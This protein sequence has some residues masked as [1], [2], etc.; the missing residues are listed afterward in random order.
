[1]SPKVYDT[2]MKI[3]KFISN[4]CFLKKNESIRIVAKIY[5][6]VHAICAVSLAFSLL[7][8]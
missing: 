7:Y 1:M 8:Y 6:V 5:S 2:K 4:F 3:F